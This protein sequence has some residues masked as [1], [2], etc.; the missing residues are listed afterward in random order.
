MTLIRTNQ[1]LFP[2]FSSLFDEFFNSGLADW[3]RHNYSASNTS[4]PKVNIKEDENG[5]VVEMAA[6]GMDKDDFNIKL[7]NNLLTVSS[8]KEEGQLGKDET[9]T[10]KEFSYQAFHRS[11]TLPNS[12]NGEKIGAS[13]KNG[14]LSIFIPKK[15]EA[16]PKPPKSISVA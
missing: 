4:L 1:D 11:F 14:I 2:S 5:F 16:K 3:R 15:E 8:E 10:R 12:V 7:D 6:P 9:Y 13:Y